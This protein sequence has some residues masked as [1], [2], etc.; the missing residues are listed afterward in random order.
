MMLFE[1]VQYQLYEIELGNY[2]NV[3]LS[4]GCYLIV[5]WQFRIPSLIAENDLLFFSARS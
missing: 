1:C 5:E 2:Q 3:C 4:T